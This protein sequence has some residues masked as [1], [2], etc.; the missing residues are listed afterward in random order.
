MKIFVTGGTGF[1]GNHFLAA[2]LSAGHEVVA[3]RRPGAR[4]RIPLSAEPR[5][6][7][8]GLTDDWRNQL[9]GC[10]VLVH[11]A[12]AGVS[13]QLANWEELF[14]INVENSLHIWVQAVEAGVKRLVLCGSCL[15]YGRSAAYYEFIPAHASSVPTNAYAASKAAATVAATALAIERTVELLVLR[16]FPT[17]GEGQYIGNFWP[18]LRQAAL[19]GQDF[20]MTPGEQVRDFVP[21]QQVADAFVAALTR[22]DLKPGEPVI[23]NLGTGRPQTLR[24]FAEHWWR[25]WNAKGKLLVGALPYR[26]NEVMRY[27]PQVPPANK[28]GEPA[29]I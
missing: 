16:P 17:F 7:E 20:P 9:A 24:A 5:W 26:E 18:A 21:V 13:P 15:E 25:H 10:E 8:G 27:V 2:A 3:L 14:K 1:V 29:S 22:A 11:F 23:E 4:S 12:A 28:H 6:V 19:A